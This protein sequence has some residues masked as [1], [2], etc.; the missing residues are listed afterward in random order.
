LL[1]QRHDHQESGSPRCST[2]WH[3]PPMGFLNP[4]TVYASRRCACL[5]SYRRHSWSS[6]SQ[7]HSESLCT[8]SLASQTRDA[9]CHGVIWPQATHITC[10]PC[11]KSD[12]SYTKITSDTQRVA[13]T[14]PFTIT[15]GP[16]STGHEKRTEHATACTLNH[17]P[18]AE[19]V[20][21][22][23]PEHRTTHANQRLTAT[24][25]KPATTARAFLVPQP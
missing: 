25:S 15:R 13:H 8:L 22:T 14:K 7:Q 4:S 23:T 10:N 2:T 11:S 6:K 20:G 17:P 18:Q 9:C 21:S 12:L 5:I 16:R 1:L 3:L 19:S 24:A